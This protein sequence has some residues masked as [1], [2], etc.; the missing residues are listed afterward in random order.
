MAIKYTNI[1]HCKSLQNLPQI[2]IFGLKLCHHL[3]T[4]RSSFYFA[5]KASKKQEV[6]IGVGSNRTNFS[7]RTSMFAQVLQISFW[8]TPF[9]SVG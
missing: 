5:E 6:K 3:A 2:R 8:K 9:L 4:L 7:T 1:F